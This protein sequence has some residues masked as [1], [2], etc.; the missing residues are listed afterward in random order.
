MGTTTV[1]LQSGVTEVATATLTVAEPHSIRINLRPNN[2]LIR[3]EVFMVHCILYTGEHAMTAG[4]D[5]LIRLM[6]EGEADV[7]LF[8][9]TE[10]GTLTDAVAKNVGQFTVTA[11]LHS[12]AGKELSRKVS[13]ATYTS[14]CSPSLWNN[15]KYSIL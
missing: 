15:K 10:N 7:D 6:V 11:R 8:R 5:I 9:S 12:I 1:Y 13:L 4:D 2:L 14:D 3:D